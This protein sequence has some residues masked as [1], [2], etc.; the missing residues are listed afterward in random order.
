[1]HC[2]RRLRRLARA[3]VAAEDGC[4]LWTREAG[5]TSPAVTGQAVVH[6]HFFVEM[7]FVQARPGGNQRSVWAAA[8]AALLQALCLIACSPCP[9]VP[10]RGRTVV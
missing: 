1:V 8:K 9:G 7:L 3:S 5:D 6:N 10:P 4:R 2:R